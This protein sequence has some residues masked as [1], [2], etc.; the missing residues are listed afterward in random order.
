MKHQRIALPMMVL[1][2]SFSVCLHAQE[3]FDPDELFR[4][5]RDLGFAGQREES[6]SICHR[7]LEQYPD[8]R[9]VRV[10]LG[11]LHSWD[12]QYDE[13]RRT[14]LDALS[15]SPEATDA[16]TALVDVELWSGNPNPALEHS[17][18]GLLTA[19]ANEALLYRKAVALSRL[20]RNDEAGR[21]LEYLLARN[22][23]HQEARSLR[24]ELGAGTEPY[25]FTADFAY[26]HL[27]LL[28]AWQEGSVSL[29]RRTRRGSVAG[30]LNYARRFAATGHQYEMD[31]YPTVRQGLYAYLNFGYSVG[32]VF[33][34]HRAGIELYANPGKGL[35]FSGGFRYLHFSRDV[36]I[37]TGSAGKYFGNYFVN[38]RPYITPGTTGTTASA[39]FMLRR[40]YSNSDSYIGFSAGAGSAPDDA[41]NAIDLER[42]HSFK[43]GGFG[44]LPMGSGIYWSFG[45]T[46]ERERLALDARRNRIHVTTG[47]VRRF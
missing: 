40:Y 24:E 45:A 20:S 21:T 6:R 9:E 1:V 11:R 42:L 29:S 36:W 12:G 26:E 4:K 2:L 27:S 17:E 5:A 32:S 19:P 31:L 37:Y 3:R 41:V 10:F 8:Y 28:S 22:P 38:I 30:R 43:A 47:L 7:I 23:A 44:S 33:P 39:T 25:R 16:R 15:G 46:W 13:A 14:L 35:E 18:A 34:R